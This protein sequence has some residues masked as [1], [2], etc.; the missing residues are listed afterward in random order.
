ME[1]GDENE[2]I[3]QTKAAGKQAGKN[4]QPP[5]KM[6]KLSQADLYKPP[7]N[8]E[9]NS[10]KETKNL[11]HSSLFRMQVRFRFLLLVVIDL[12]SNYA[13]CKKSVHSCAFLL[14]YENRNFF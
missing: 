5:Q 13:I 3:A 6:A 10:L 14:T 9:L 7:T 1:S 2:D 12:V 11:F 4:G 8:E